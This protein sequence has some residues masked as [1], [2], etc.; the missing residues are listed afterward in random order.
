MP[1][2]EHPLIQAMRERFLAQLRGSKRSRDAR[3]LRYRL[4]VAAAIL[5][6]SVCLVIAYILLHLW[7]VLR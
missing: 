6:I 4:L 2:N 5:G 1:T 3:A 7:Y